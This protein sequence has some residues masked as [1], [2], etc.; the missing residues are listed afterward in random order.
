MKSSATK[1][2]TGLFYMFLLSGIPNLPRLNHQKMSESLKHNFYSK[3]SVKAAAGEEDEDIF[4][5]FVLPTVAPHCSEIHSDLT[6]NH[7]L[8]LFPVQS[9]KQPYVTMCTDYNKAADHQFI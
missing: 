3:L 2:K 7:K 1:E 4:I 8:K 6:D 9:E 5:H